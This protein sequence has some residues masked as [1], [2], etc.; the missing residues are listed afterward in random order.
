MHPLFG[1]QTTLREPLSGRDF[2]QLTAG[3]MAALLMVGLIWWVGYRADRSDFAP[4][5]GA[6]TGLWVAY[7]VLMALGRRG[8]LPYSRLVGLGVLLRVLL[9]F[10]LPTLSDDVYRFLW[11]GHLLARGI[12]P[13]AFTPQQVLQQGLVTGEFALDLFERL[14]SPQYYTVYPPVCQ[15]VF[16]LAALGF[17]GDMV[18]GIWMMKLFLL[19]MEVVALWSLWRLPAGP[20]A[21]ALYALNPLVLVE[22]MGNAHFEGAAVA[23]LLVG[24]LLLCRRQWL[25]GALF[26]ALAIATKLLPLLFL[27][28]LWLHLN[29]RAR[30]KFLGGVALFCAALFAPL[31]DVEALGNLFSGLRLYFQQFTFNAGIYYALKGLLKAAGQEAFLQA[32]LLGPS[33]GFLTMLGAWAIAL[34]RSKSPSVLSVEERLVLT[35]ALYLLLSATVHPW[36]V[37]VPFGL[38]QVSDAGRQWRFPLVWSA[39]IALSYSHY[40]D[41]RFQEKYLC[42]ALEYAAVGA[43]LGW[44]MYCRRF[45][46]KA[47]LSTRREPG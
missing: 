31:A 1:K 24:W 26:W 12:H 43:A 5:I 23:F 46:P 10:S 8:E 6:F 21:A 40:A 19:V 45:S 25:S 41:G 27:P 32:R 13:F 22:V 15:G 16:A 11:D 37:I 4:L 14:N 39:V 38:S 47:P 42:I 18:G 30:W 20:K 34:Y 35:V 7:V 17:P 28:A 44:D 9:L 29:G 36:Y 2:R 3:L 33:L